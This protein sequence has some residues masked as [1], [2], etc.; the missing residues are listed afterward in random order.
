LRIILISADHCLL[1][2][3]ISRLS[4]PG[5]I[6]I[7]GFCRPGATW[8]NAFKRVIASS[9]G[10]SIVHGHVPHEFGDLAI[11]LGYRRARQNIM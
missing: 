3:D 10:R 9:A 4:R 2:T 8:V 6:G 11:D 5:F 7:A 1:V